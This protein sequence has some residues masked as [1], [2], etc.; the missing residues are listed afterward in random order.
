M[1]AEQWVAAEDLAAV[2]GFTAVVAVDLVAAVVGVVS[3]SSVI[4]LVDRETR[5]GEKLYAANEADLRQM[6][7]DQSP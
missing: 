4:W 6:L 5:N 1:A 7:L 2:E 3:R